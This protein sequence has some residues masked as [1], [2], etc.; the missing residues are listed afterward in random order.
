MNN[1]SFD[2]MV[3]RM[4][5]IRNREDAE[6][7]RLTTDPSVYN[8]AQML[9][10]RLCDCLTQLCNYDHAVN[11]NGGKTPILDVITE[12]ERSVRDEFRRVTGRD[13]VPAI[14][15]QVDFRNSNIN[16]AKE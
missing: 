7:R 14:C 8:I 6:L 15:R 2:V 13:Y 10:D 5:E 11:G 16:A 1:D 3:Q 4:N 9:T 12:L